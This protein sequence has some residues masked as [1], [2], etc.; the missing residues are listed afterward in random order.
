MKKIYA[1]TFIAAYLLPL[2]VSANQQLKGEVFS[3][4]QGIICDKKS[5]FCADAEGISLGYT[6]EYLGKDAAAEFEK[7]ISSVKNFD[8]TSFVLSNGVL[9]DAK[10]KHCY[11][12]KYDNIVDKPHT[13]AMF[14]AT[15]Y[16]GDAGQRMA[17]EALKGI[18][19]SGLENLE[20]K[21]KGK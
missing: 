16:T 11:T 12:N 20:Q 17:Q 8:T 19:T 15:T 3:P 9:C 14:E 2:S 10:K 4:E 21:L 1:F 7:I 18:D 5:G 13:E 6:G